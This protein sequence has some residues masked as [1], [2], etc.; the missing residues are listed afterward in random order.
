MEQATLKIFGTGQVTIPKK[1]RD[2][3]NTDTLKAVFDQKTKS[4]QIK[5]IKMLEL[6]NFIPMTSQDFK[7][8][9]EESNFSKD[10][11]KDIVDGFKDSSMCINKNNLKK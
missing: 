10:F 11:I 1:W 5:P 8:G 6:E 7:E 9:L 4:I 3:F 2:F